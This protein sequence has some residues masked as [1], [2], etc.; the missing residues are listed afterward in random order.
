[1]GF[2]L[3]SLLPPFF[4]YF[5]F[6]FFNSYRLTLS[7]E[8]ILRTSF[9]HFN[10]ITRGTSTLFKILESYARTSSSS[11]YLLV[12]FS[13]YCFYIAVFFTLAFTVSFKQARNS[14]FLANQC[15]ISLCCHL[16]ILALNSK[17]DRE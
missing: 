6:A 17:V 5:S 11:H 16:R 10:P 14:Y 7:S 12:F 15:H 2:H 3:P 1:M 9:F 4:I 13:L 8:K